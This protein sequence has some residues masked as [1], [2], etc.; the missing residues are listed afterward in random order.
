VHIQALQ[1]DLADK[2]RYITTLE[3]R[4]LHARRSSHSRVSMSL[5]HKLGG[6]SED[7]GM[8]AAIAEKD[9]EISNLRAQL[10]DKE[11]MIAAL[12][13]ARK[14]NDNAHDMGSDGSPG[15][16][17]TSGYQRSGSD[18]S[19]ASVGAKGPTSPANS[20]KA[21]FLPP[22]ATTST[23]KNIE[24]MTRMLDEMITGRVEKTARRSSLMPATEGR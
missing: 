4:L 20:A 10:E 24:E 9:N 16:Q 21:P 19:G 3:K 5:S 1:A 22:P 8:I 15:S 23:G 17:R 6:S 11:R 18:G 7:G 2:N 13:S 14:K 12:T